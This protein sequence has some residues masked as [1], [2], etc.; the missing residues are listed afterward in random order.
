MKVFF[1]P[2]AAIRFI[3][4]T[5]KEFTRSVIRPN[6]IVENGD[7]LIMTPVDAYNTV[8]LFPTEWEK[9]ENLEIDTDTITLNERI[10]E[11][12]SEVDELSLVVAEH[13]KVDAVTLAITQDEAMTTIVI[14]A[15]EEFAEDINALAEYALDEFGIELED[16]EKT[17]DELYAELYFVVNHNDDKQAESK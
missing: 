6:P 2:Y 3:G 8:R 10:K 9:V 14:K 7:I 5:K 15:K 11:L 13:D 16:L 12:E 17:F 4:E 1:Y